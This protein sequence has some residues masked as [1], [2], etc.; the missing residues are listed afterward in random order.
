MPAKKSDKRQQDV[1]FQIRMR[2]V[3]RNYLES[4]AE[5]LSKQSPVKVALGPFLK[6]AAI[7]ETAKLTGVTFESFAVEQARREK[8]AV[9]LGE[10]REGVREM[11]GSSKKPKKGGGR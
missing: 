7:Q 5:A 11:V 2:E 4:G 6:W 8:N 3:E 10:I 1:P 9:L